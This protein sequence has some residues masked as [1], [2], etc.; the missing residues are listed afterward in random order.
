M[1]IGGSGTRWTNTKNEDSPL[2]C[3]VLEGGSIT[4]N[5]REQNA[6]L[7]LLMVVKKTPDQEV[8][9]S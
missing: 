1:Q 3:Q 9:K 6:F 5:Y 7:K 2:K 4:F 8:D